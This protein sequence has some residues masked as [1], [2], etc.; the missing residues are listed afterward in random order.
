MV[1]IRA[2]LVFFK[3]QCASDMISRILYAFSSLALNGV[4]GSITLLTAHVLNI[5][6][7]VHSTH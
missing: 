5:N 3:F 6:E 1:C 4:N 7:M 2:E